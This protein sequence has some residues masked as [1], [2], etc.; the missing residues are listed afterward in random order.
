MGRGPDQPAAEHGLHSCSGPLMPQLPANRPLPADSPHPAARKSRTVSAVSPTAEQQRAGE[1]L[2]LALLWNQFVF[3]GILG[4]FFGPLVL[5]GL[6]G[7]L[8]V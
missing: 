4:S 3:A 5:D 7:L 6:A 8:F 2:A 1:L